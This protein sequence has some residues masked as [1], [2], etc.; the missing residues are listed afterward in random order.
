MEPWNP[1]TT[2]LCLVCDAPS[3]LNSYLCV[4]CRPLKDRKDARLSQRDFRKRL[5]TMRHQLD[6]V[7]DVFLCHFTGAPMLTDGPKHHPRFA[8]WEHLDPRNDSEVVLACRLVNSMKGNMK[9]QEFKDMV[10]AL[11]AKFAASDDKEHVFP[12]E[13]WPEPRPDLIL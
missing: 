2:E 7:R 3:V 9:E 10:A 5:E 11:A 13:A 6:R 12:D 4:R 1:A 8:T